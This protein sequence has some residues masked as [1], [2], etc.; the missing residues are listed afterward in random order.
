MEK[1]EF[2][3]LL[4]ATAG[5]VLAIVSIGWNIALHFLSLPNIKVTATTSFLYP[6]PPGIQDGEEL[7]VIQAVNTR[8]RVVTITSFCMTGGGKGPKNYFIKGSAGPLQHFSTTLPSSLN[9]GQQAT[10]MMRRQQTNPDLRLEDIKYFIAWDTAGRQWKSRRYP[11]RKQS[12]KR[13]KA[14]RNLNP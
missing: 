2:W 4:I 1:Y 13:T 7:L 5:L 6:S 9:E 8:T 14:S 11:L 10:L 12:K 3:T